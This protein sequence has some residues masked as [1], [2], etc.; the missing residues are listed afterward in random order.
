M[1]ACVRAV[2]TIC[3]NDCEI[4]APDSN[5]QSSSLEQTV[6]EMP[7]M[8]HVE[9]ECLACLVEPRWHRQLFLLPGLNLFDLF[10]EVCKQ[11]G[12]QCG[13]SSST[14]RQPSS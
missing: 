4:P 3:E 7:N 1:S 14:N 10:R 9:G 6:F 13:K 5:R 2:Q 11:R 12:T 8:S